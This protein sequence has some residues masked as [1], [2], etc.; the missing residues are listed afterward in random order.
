MAELEGKLR[1]A[2]ASV[3]MTSLEANLRIGSELGEKP[4]GFRFLKI[5]HELAAERER[6]WNKWGEQ[7]YPSVDEVLST[8][9]GG[10]TPERMA[11][12][13]EVPSELR[14]KALLELARDRGA[15]TWSHV[16]VEE[17]CEAIAA[18]GDGPR[19]AELVQVAAV[20]CSW[21]DCID[22]RAFESSRKAG[23]S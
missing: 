12:E 14:A 16:L 21:I 2:G 18:D 3:S 20:C 8:R 10:C 9:E 15:L 22:R 7:N 13:Y 4:W 6:I 23:A 1:Q 11:E 19:R 17:A 5:A